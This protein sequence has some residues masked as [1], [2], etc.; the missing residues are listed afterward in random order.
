MLTLSTIAI[1][2]LVVEFPDN[3]AAG[4]IS[5][6]IDPQMGE[7][8]AI[9]V[10]HRAAHNALCGRFTCQGRFIYYCR[11]SAADFH[12]IKTVYEEMHPSHFVSFAD[13]DALG[14]DAITR[15][16]LTVRQPTLEELVET[17]VPLLNHPSKM[18]GGE[19]ALQ[20]QGRVRQVYAV[21]ELWPAD[22]R[23]T[24]GRV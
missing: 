18:W 12:L 8:V 1:G 22:S 11:M 10:G 24:D 23:R 13:E 15:T 17:L 5:N 6:R 2:R 4:L 3:D 9:Y 16:V 21:P 7:R 19:P 20:R 14:S